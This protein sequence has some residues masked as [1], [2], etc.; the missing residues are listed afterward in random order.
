M[1]AAPT[2]RSGAARL[3]VGTAVRVLP[4]A[5]GFTR[6]PAW[7][8]GR[9]GRVVRLIGTWPEPEAVARGQ[10]DATARRLYHVVFDGEVEFAA[11]IYEHWLEP[12]ERH[13]ARA[14]GGG[15]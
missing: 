7:A 15:S 8:H 4:S 10:R 1:D 12:A 14:D 9:V 5:G 13:E 3:E 6:T 11:D 2:A